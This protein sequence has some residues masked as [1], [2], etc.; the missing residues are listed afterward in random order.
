M[1]SPHSFDLSENFRPGDTKPQDA[2]VAFSE[3][4]NDARAAEQAF[5]WM[6]RQFTNYPHQQWN[7]FLPSPTFMSV[8][9]LGQQIEATVAADNLH[10]G[11]LEVPREL[12]QRLDGLHYYLDGRGGYDSGPNFPFCKHERLFDDN[13]WIGLA[14]MDVY[15]QYPS[16]TNMLDDANKV[17]EFEKQGAEQARKAPKEPGGVMWLDGD[18]NPGYRSTVST[19]GATQLALRLYKQT[20]DPQYLDFAKEQFDWVDKNLRTDSGLYLDGEEWNGTKHDGTFS[21]NQGLMLGDAAML[22]EATGDTRYRDKAL[23]ITEASLKYLTEQELESQQPIFNAI[24]FKNLIKADEILG[25]PPAVRQQ[26]REVIKGYSDYL[27]AN[28]N[29]EGHVIRPNR[30][31][32]EDLSWSNLT[33]SAAVQIFAME[34]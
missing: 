31:P 25:A 10:N 11:D 21:Y 19:A 15:E 33:Q 8:W 3:Q 5:R 29:S 16:K 18:T 1:P 9:P 6:N 4:V 17:F 30:D 14:L 26:H 32:H 13:A 22:Y 27:K 24:F 12:D 7:Q 20:H 34:V 23:Q 2:S 28:M